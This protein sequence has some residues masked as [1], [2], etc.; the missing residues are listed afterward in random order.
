MRILYFLQ[1]A[2]IMAMTMI[3]NIITFIY[4]VVTFFIIKPYKILFC[5]YIWELYFLY[6]TLVISNVSLPQVL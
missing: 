5:F 4:H 1:I 2:E 6:S 3:T